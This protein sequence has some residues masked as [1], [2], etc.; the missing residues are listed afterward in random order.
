[1]PTIT[2]RVSGDE[3]ADVERRAA[4][5]GLDLSA[6]VRRAL[7]LEREAPDLAGRLDAVERRVTTLEQV[8]GLE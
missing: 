2:I 8:A 4:A 7:D 1:M 3:K 6:F 5:A